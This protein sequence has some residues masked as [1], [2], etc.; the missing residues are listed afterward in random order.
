MPRA[1]LRNQLLAL[2]TNMFATSAV[3]ATLKTSSVAHLENF[4]ANLCVRVMDPGFVSARAS[5]KQEKFR[6][7]SVD[8]PAGPREAMCYVY[9]EAYK[10]WVPW[11]PNSLLQIHDWNAIWNRPHW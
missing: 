7:R 6:V 9:D 3:C 8:S 1:A 10:N 11:G 4:D 2:N 5:P